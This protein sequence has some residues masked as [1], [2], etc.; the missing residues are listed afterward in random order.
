MMENVKPTDAELEIL[1]VLWENG[2]SSVRAVND[3]L[4]ESRDVGY[5]TTLKLLQIMHEK[6][7]VTRNTES[8]SHIYTAQVS[9]ENVQKDLLNKFLDLAFQGSA[10]KL[11]MQLLGNERTSPGELD[12]IKALIQEMEN[13]QQ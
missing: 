1:Q 11:V 4:N 7:L 13:K 5:T 8:R 10:S 2:P 12:E 3:T 6:G 9:R